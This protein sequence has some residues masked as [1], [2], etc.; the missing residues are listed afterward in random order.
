MKKTAANKQFNNLSLTCAIIAA[1]ICALTLWMSGSPYEMVHKLDSKNILPPIWIW[2]LTYL[3]WFFLLGLGVGKIMSA[4]CAGCISGEREIS[5]YKGGIFFITA[6]FCALIHYPLFFSAER[7]F[8]S[9][10]IALVAVLCSLIC[11]VIWS[12]IST[13][14]SVVMYAYSFW[15]FYTI[16]INACILFQN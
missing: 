6:F 5:A 8:I 10:I 13:F 16:F 9:L 15:L 14:T 3:I 7:I 4:A 1:V 11:A 2:R 12:K